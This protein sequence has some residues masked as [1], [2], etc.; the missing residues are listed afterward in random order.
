MF[1]HLEAS[2]P[3]APTKSSYPV[4]AVIFIASVMVPI[5][6]LLSLSWLCWSVAKRP[7]AS[8]RDRTRLYRVTELVGKWSMTD[9][10]VVAV[11]VSFLGTNSSE[12]TAAT[13]GVGVYFFAAYGVLA[14][15]VGQLMLRAERPLE[16]TSE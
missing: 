15:A 5:G 16:Q 10:F 1:P 3:R 14:V 4:A 6:K 9:V 2:A 7:D 12:T 11:L 8:N 13:L